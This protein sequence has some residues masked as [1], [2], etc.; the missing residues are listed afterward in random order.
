MEVEA[1]ILSAARDCFKLE[2]DLHDEK[3]LIEIERVVSYSKVLIRMCKY[4]T[5]CDSTKIDCL[6]SNRANSPALSTRDEL[7][8][9]RLS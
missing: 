1:L 2:Y 5:C 6:L 8:K 4:F 3:P 7:D 9:V